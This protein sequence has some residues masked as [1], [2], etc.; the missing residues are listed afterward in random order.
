M[1]SNQGSV[2]ID[3][4]DSNLYDKYRIPVAIDSICDLLVDQKERLD[5]SLSLLSLC[6]GTGSNEAQILSSLNRRK[7]A[8]LDSLYCADYSKTMLANA[9]RR[10]S[11]HTIHTDL[12]FYELDVLNSAWPGQADSILCCQ[13][14]HHFD[15]QDDRFPNV[16]R[17]FE[18]AAEYLPD[19]GQLILTF[20]TPLQM[21]EA[22]WYTAIRLRDEAPDPAE[23][24]S[25]EFPPLELLLG[26]L[27]NTG[28]TLDFLEPIEGPHAPEESFTDHTLLHDRTFQDSDSFFSMARDSGLLEKY[29]HRV[30][31][32]SSRETLQDHIE[33]AEERRQEI[34]ISYLLCASVER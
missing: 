17:F 31:E 2:L 15:Q 16:L 34:G 3:Y 33:S 19:Q 9:K 1:P 14:I 27:H 20:S 30:R 24:Y 4:D 32:M 21:L 26:H 8:R 29:L 6:C 7:N 23:M 10:L 25:S 5:S 22:Q 18:K 13:A 12:S 28:F 11:T